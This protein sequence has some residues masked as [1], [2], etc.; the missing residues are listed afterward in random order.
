VPVGGEHRAEL[1]LRVAA[2]DDKG[3]TS[4]IPVV[5]ITISAKQPP[6]RDQ[7]FT[8]STSLELRKQRHQL[9]VAVYDRASGTLLSTTAEV[10]P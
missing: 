10:A 1:E 4:D 7:F 8:Y 5:P 3:R 9:V 2:L 6:G